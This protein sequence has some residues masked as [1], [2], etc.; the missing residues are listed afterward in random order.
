MYLVK[1]EKITPTRKQRTALIPEVMV[2]MAYQ[3]STVNM[4]EIFI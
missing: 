3:E 2:K 4:A 1:M